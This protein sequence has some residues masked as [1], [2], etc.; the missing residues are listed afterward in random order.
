MSN[1]RSRTRTSKRPP[2]SPDGPAA[3]PVGDALSRP[4]PHDPDA[5]R[6]VL[7]AMLIERE[8]I[9]EVITVLEA[10]GA[11]AFFSERHRQLYQVLVELYQQDKL[12]D[13]LV[14]KDELVRRGLFEPLG[15]FEFLTA[16]VSAVPSAQRAR[17][18]AHI[19]RDRALSR[20]LIDAT[21]R[22]SEAAFEDSLP[23]TE[24]LDFAEGE[25]F[26]V[27]ERRVTG[28]AT[29]L[30][31]LV[32]ETFRQIESRGE[33]ALTGE[34]TGYHKLDELTCG[35]QPSELIII[36]ARPSMGKTALVLNIAEHMAIVEKPARPVLFFSLEMSKQQLVERIL[37][38]R[39]RVDSHRLRRGM[40]SAGEVSR[41]QHAAHLIGD[42]PLYVDD[43]SSLS[44][45]ELRAR[46]RLAW[47][48]YRIRA[49]FVDYL[50]LMRAPGTDSRQEEVA[51]IS[52][53]LK[54]LAKDLKIPVIAA[55][56][57]NRNPEE[58]TGNRPR[59]ADLRESGAIE[60]DAD[61][62]ALL[63]RETYYKTK[64][65]DEVPGGDDEDNVAELIIAKQRNGPT[66][67]IKLVWNK[68]YTRFDNLKIGETGSY[69][70]A[71]TE[72]D[73]G[74]GASATRFSQDAPF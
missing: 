12:V 18:Y 54:A 52:R 61:V 57:L 39:G 64:G 19:V 53:G 6:A 55:A 51:T 34:P 1:L 47:R 72:I 50:Q 68:Q 28:G 27:T 5:E 15:G 42:K 31:E 65:P 8:T 71:A 11:G 74:D 62:V 66:D 56:Q 48:K 59:M 17:H 73:P 70:P 30:Q 14:V 41:L 37:C 7:G 33:D 44:I 29:N 13:D 22:V 3:E 26:A 69:A 20:Q 36:A 25:I 21:H 16:L 49:I 38:S 40:L 9:G 46:A 32:R 4:L 43:T 23:A 63:H 2:T 45:L 58:R 67:T 24:L 10:L 60:Q 35:L